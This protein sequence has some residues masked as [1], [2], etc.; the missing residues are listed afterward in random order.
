M[1][2]HT[3]VCSMITMLIVLMLVM[4]LFDRIFLLLAVQ[5]GFIL[6]FFVALFRPEIER[7]WDAI[8]SEDGQ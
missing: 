3:T 2:K 6:S 4:T 1:N 7:E 8:K 5:A